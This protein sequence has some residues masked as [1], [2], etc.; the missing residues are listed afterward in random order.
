MYAS[1][2]RA[3]LFDVNDF[4]ETLP[5]PWEWDVKRIAASIVVASWVNG[6]DDSD[7]RR[8]A[9]SATGSYRERMA[10]F[11]EMGELEV[12]YSRIGEEEVRGLLSA[13]RARRRTAKKLSKTV[14]KAR[15][16]DSLQALS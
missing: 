13:A 9:L 15:G 3:L 10:K 12:W 7:C 6:F 8:A 2:E 14:Q 11:S 5:G 4:D 16:R 1:P